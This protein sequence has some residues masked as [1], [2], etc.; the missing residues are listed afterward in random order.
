MIET[1]DNFQPIEGGYDFLVDFSDLTF[2]AHR[3]AREH[4]YL[5]IKNRIGVHRQ[6]VLKGLFWDDL[7]IGFQNRLLRDP[8]T[9]H[10]KFWNHMQILLPQ[11]PPDWDSFLRKQRHDRKPARAVWKPPTRSDSISKITIATSFSKYSTSFSSCMLKLCSYK[12]QESSEF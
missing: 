6:T 11:Q 4:A 9:F 2:P 12:I 3:P 10:Y 8:D 7:Y 1:D 5:Q